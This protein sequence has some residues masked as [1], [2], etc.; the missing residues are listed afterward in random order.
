MTATDGEAEFAALVRRHRHELYRYCRRLLGSPELAEDAVQDA[1]L[2]AWR[3]R[4][5]LR[6]RGSARPWLYT[7]ARHACVDRI[8][9]ERGR[10]VADAAPTA[11]EEGRA[12][13]PHE[14]VVDRETV[15]LA[16]SAAVDVLPPRQRDALLLCDVLDLPPGEAAGLLGTRVAAVNSALQRARAGLRRELDLE[17]RDDWGAAGPPSE[18]AA[19][20]RLVDRIA[21]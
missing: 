16:V 7:I 1:L 13:D 4:A 17:R 12:S 8:Q 2:R 19:A 20:G 11:G 9:R 15:E 18:R 10:P 3:G 5:R 21:A 6:R 14:T